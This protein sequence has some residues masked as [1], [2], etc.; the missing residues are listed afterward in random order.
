MIKSKHLFIVSL[1]I[2]LI[3]I[4]VYLPALQNDFVNWDDD[5]YVYENPNIQH[6][7]LQSIRWMFTT[8]H[9]SNWHPLTWL[10]HAIDYAV[11]GLNPAGHHLTSIVLHG[12]NTF[13]VVILIMLLLQL[14]RDKYRTGVTI[15]ENKQSF[16]TSIIA[17]AVTGLL[18]GLHPVHVESVV[19]VSERKDVL[20]SFFFLMSVLVY[21]QYTVSVHT[22][23]TLLYTL[24]LLFFIL[25]LLSKPMA[26]TLPAVLI[27]L[28]VYPL[29]RLEI[30]SKRLRIIFMEKVPFVALGFASSFVTIAA[31]QDFWTGCS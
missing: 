5:E 18:F 3:T 2:S 10:S 4:L 8:F 26:V 27:I 25:S 17:A 16:D 14:A 20:Y 28:D 7:G 23:R 13:L 24:C 11:W 29:G 12:I 21:M 30:G 6:I 22:K 19:W 1:F 9:A 31:Q 15:E